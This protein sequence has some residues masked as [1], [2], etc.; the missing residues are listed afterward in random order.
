MLN[1]FGQFNCALRNDSNHSVYYF[2]AN[3]TFGWWLQL[4]NE[5]NGQ[6]VGVIPPNSHL[7]FNVE[8]LNIAQN[9]GEE[10]M[11]KLEQ[12]GVE[13]AAGAALCFAYLAF[14]PILQKNGFPF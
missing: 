2:L 12:F 14:S 11:M 8:L 3:W 6:P 13:R 7:E 1:V 5:F 9:P 4:P 10:F